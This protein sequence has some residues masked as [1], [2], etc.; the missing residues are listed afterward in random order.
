M[1]MRRWQLIIVA[2]S[3]AGGAQAQ[4]VA[5]P[6]PAPTPPEPIHATPHSETPLQAAPQLCVSAGT[7]MELADYLKHG[8]VVLQLIGESAGQIQRE[9]A[10]EQKPAAPPPPATPPSLTT[11]PPKPPR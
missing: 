11:P 1:E 9:A 6:P 8:G 3:A 5:V 2:L 4:A 10:A 7:A